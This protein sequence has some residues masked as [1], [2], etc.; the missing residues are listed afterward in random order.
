[1]ANMLWALLSILVL[2]IP[3][4]IV[5]LLSVMFRWMDDRNP[6]PFATFFGTIQRTWLKS[7]LVAVI[8]ILIGGFL[9]V[10][11]TILRQMESSNIMAFLSQAVTLFVVFVFILT[12]IYIWTLIS[13]WDAPLKFILKFSVQLVFAQP[14]WSFA[15]GFSIVSSLIFSMIFPVAIYVFCMGAIVA[16]IACKGTW[17]VV[18]KYISPQ[19]FA[20]IDI[21]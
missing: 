6:Q 18:K 14:L 8:D 16:Y 12:N 19:Q 20:L 11:L 5:G 17:F 1:M 15:I 21:S 3:L 9:F 10:N 2:T 13:I 7:Y 4:G